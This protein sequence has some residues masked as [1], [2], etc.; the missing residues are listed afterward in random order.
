MPLTARTN[1]GEMNLLHNSRNLLIES[2]T[3]YA[4]FG[5]VWGRGGSGVRGTRRPSSKSTGGARCCQCLRVKA[6]KW[7]PSV[8][9]LEI[10]GLKAPH[11]ASSL[12]SRSRKRWTSVVLHVWKDTQKRS[13]RETKMEPAKI[14]GQNWRNPTASPDFLLLTALTLR[15]FF[16]RLHPDNASP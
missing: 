13:H 15:T 7:R 11:A 14:Q 8:E 6:S 16:L 3:W 12:G 9:A 10:V 1:P 2:A 5:D 4:P